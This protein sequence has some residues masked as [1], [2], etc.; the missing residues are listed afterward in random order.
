MDP[1]EF[2]NEKKVVLAEI[3]GD[4]ANP[5][6]I[7]KYYMDSRLFP[8]A[9]YRNDPAGSIPVVK[10]ATVSQMKDIQSH[11][12]IPQ[13]AALFVGGDV[14]PDEVYKLVE[15]IYGTWSNN[16]NPP[17]PKAP[18]QNSSPFST[19]QYAVMPYD[20]MPAQMAQ[21]LVRFRAP[22]TDFEIQD[23]YTADYLHF[24]IS[25]P[26]GIF[27]KEL[28]EDE[29]LAIPSVDYIDGSY[30]TV[31]ASG[32]FEF[33][34]GLLSP[35]DNL[36]QRID[37]L[38][39]RIQG[40][41]LPAVADNAELY[42]KSKKDDV[43]GH[44]VNEDLRTAQTA[45]GL[46]SS[47]SFWWCAS[48]P[49]YYYSYNKKMADVS[50]KDM[51]SFVDK[52][53]TDKKP[54]VT[55]LINP[56]VYSS[57][58]E[59]ADK[60]GWEEISSQN[61]FWWKNEKFAPDKAKIEA[62]KALPVAKVE[63]AY[64]PLDNKE[65]QNVK[66]SEDI[67]KLYLDNGIPVFIRR[68]PNSDVDSVSIAVKGGVER[69]TKE[70]SGLENALFTMMSK[71]SASYDFDT[72]HVICYNASCQIQGDSKL[73]G[74]S[75]SMDVVHPHLYDTL[76]LLVDGFLNPDYEERVYDIVM[77]DFRQNV[78][79]TLNSPSHLLNYEMI[80]TVYE[81]HPYEARSVVTVD[82][83]DNITIENMK[84]LHKRLLDPKY[85]FV[86][87]VIKDDASKVVEELNKTL[88]K[89]GPAEKS[90]VLFKDIPPL[91]I[92]GEPVVISHSSAKG[93][94]NVMRA[95]ASPSNTEHDYIPAALASSIY[96]DIMFNVV[97]ERRGVCY[98][99]YSTITGSK[100][101]VG[102]ESLFSLSDYQNF[103]SAMNE[104]RAV[105]IRGEVI[106]SLA[107]DGSY[108]YSPIQNKLN[109]YKNK[110][111]NSTFESRQESEDIAEALVYNELQFGDIH[112]SEKQLSQ[113]EQTGA[114][115]VLSVFKKYWQD[116]PSRWFVIVGP[117]DVDI[118]NSTFKN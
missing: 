108:I 59:S 16:N 92:T 10:D 95:F 87:V 100:G 37:R 45:K 23:T 56:Q 83:I 22:D 85:I 4:A 103:V 107:P 72:R 8:D 31:R 86:V 14:N 58:K 90:E 61:A 116:A 109:G 91:R 81:G 3:E 79:N 6:Y 112:Y 111:I 30:T 9:P 32:I 17:P 68:N 40:E 20:K 115:E 12:Y 51:K 25:E 89:L 82:S 47:I 42:A 65:N 99:P 28:S 96:S 98:T 113:A 118:I 5:S 13:N 76:P 36:P 62:L 19:V 64:K 55:I 102:Y 27:K 101:A 43:V 94:G 34:A 73:S 66:F 15:R 46:L 44:I 57:I 67:D 80:K 110:F 21:V 88:G 78:Q 1:V 2:E 53:F 50:Q 69:L 18:K 93:S 60:A 33:F 114:S 54:L 48:S 70:T 39:E 26:D 77:H 105:M 75:L 38:L 24:L 11:Y 35:E 63:E 84:A 52:Y 49:E 7:L 29:T 117:G 106:D 41:L 104:A 71:S 97:R 74:S